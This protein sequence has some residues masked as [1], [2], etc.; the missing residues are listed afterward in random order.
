MI[1]DDFKRDIVG[2]AKL[3]IKAL[4]FI[5]YVKSPDLRIPLSLRKHVV[6]CRDYDDVIRELK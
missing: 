4:W 5:K 3:G 1:G 6:I 2:A